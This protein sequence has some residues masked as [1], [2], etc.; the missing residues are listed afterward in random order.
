MSQALCGPTR[1]FE[2]PI[3][4]QA[5]N[6]ALLA[7]QDVGLAPRDCA[8]LNGDSSIMWISEG[9]RLIAF[10]VYFQHRGRTFIDLIHVEPAFRRRGLGTMLLQ[11]VVAAASARHD[12]KIWVM[13][14]VDN[15]AMRSLSERAGF[16][17]TSIY[18]TMALMTEQSATGAV[19]DRQV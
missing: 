17:A 15:V 4:W 10:V 19:V 16:A 5:A 12:F 9:G 14:S 6:A 18:Y 11:A 8:A 3:E 1:L 7:L 13:T 2:A